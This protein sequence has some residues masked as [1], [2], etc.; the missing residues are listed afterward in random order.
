VTS[1]YLAVMFGGD[2]FGNPFN[3]MRQ[4]MQE[5]DDMMNAMMP[6]HNQMFPFGG[7][8]F[9]GRRNPR[10]QQMIGNGQRHHRDQDLMMHPFGF[11]GGLF[12]GLMQQMDRLQNH[13]MNDPHSTVITDA[14][15]ITFDNQGQPKIV[16]SSTRKAGDVKE[17]R[18]SVKKGDDLAEVSVNHSI[19]DRSHIIEKRRDKDGRMRQEQRFVNLDEEEAEDFNSE[20]KTRATRNLFGGGN[21]GGHKAIQ[22]NGRTSTKRPPTIEQG[23][24]VTV[25][26][27]DDDVIFVSQARRPKQSEENYVRSNTR[28]GPTIREIDEDE[29]DAEEPKRR[30]NLFGRFNRSN[31]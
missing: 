13:A 10:Q 29:E 3:F 16:H 9:S 17:V 27:D 25:P 23:P 22:N 19:G 5:M 24:I 31:H 12:G 14:T 6:G 18:R 2:P 26:D 21:S 30:K 4:Q 7:P 20:F 11:G 28:G 1:I 8:L 15:Q